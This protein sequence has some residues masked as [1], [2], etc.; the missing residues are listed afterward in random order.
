MPKNLSYYSGLRGRSRSVSDRSAKISPLLGLGQRGC[1]AAALICD[2][3]VA[4]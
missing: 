3:E 4:R 1:F 2:R